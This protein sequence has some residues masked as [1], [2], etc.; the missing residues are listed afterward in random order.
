MTTLIFLGTLAIA[1]T[2]AGGQTTKVE[3]GKNFPLPSGLDKGFLDTTADPCVNFAHYACGN[4]TELYPIPADR[5]AY[6]TIQV[7]SEHTEDALHS[8]LEKVE[9]DNPSRTERAKNQKVVS[10]PL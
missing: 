6:G 7:A 9:A 4:F 3:A 2:L 10:R 8:L 5:S 1:S